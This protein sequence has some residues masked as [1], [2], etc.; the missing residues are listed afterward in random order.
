MGGAAS[1]EKLARTYLGGQN[2]SHYHAQGAATLLMFQ[3]FVMGKRTGF[4]CFSKKSNFAGATN[5]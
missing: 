3:I 1:F 4:G 2:P 5:Q